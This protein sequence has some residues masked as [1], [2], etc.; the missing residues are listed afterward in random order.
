[1]I[2]FQSKSLSAGMECL[3]ASSIVSLQLYA[4]GVQNK[5]M[6]GVARINLPSSSMLL[7]PHYFVE[8]RIGGELL[9]FDFSLALACRWRVN[10]VCFSRLF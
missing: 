9:V 4:A 5:I 8:A 3:D 10:P 1:M 2:F 7:V 6:R